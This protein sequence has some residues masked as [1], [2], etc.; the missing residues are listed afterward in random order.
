[1]MTLTVTIDDKKLYYTYE[2]GTSKRSGDMVFNVDCFTFFADLLNHLAVH[3]KHQDNQ[4]MENVLVEAR[5]QERLES[6][7]AK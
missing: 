7:K 3:N 5:V 6:L 4:V 1:M 2:V